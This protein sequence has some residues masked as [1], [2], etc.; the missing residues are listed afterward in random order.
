MP[1]TKR[2]NTE[3]DCPKCEAKLVRVEHSF[4]QG[5]SAEP[6]KTNEEW[7]CASGNQHLSWGWKPP[8]ER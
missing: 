8:A 7:Q 2:Y 6:Y 1:T 5:G 3:L 4:F